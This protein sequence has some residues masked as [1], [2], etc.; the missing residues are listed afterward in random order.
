MIDDKR[1]FIFVENPKTASYSIK[2]AL[3][4]ENNIHNPLDP[5]QATINHHIPMLIK[6][7][8]PEKWE[9]YLSF[10][11]VRNTWDRAHSFFQFYRTIAHSTTYQSMSFSEWIAADCPPPKEP[12][13]C[14]PMHGDGRFDDVLDQTR[15]IEEVDEII[16]LHALSKQEQIRALQ[17]G[18]NR[19]CKLL[20]IHS[21]PIPVDGNNY[22]R[23]KQAIIWEKASIEHIH[24]K[25]RTEID[26]FN[27]QPPT[28]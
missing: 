15:Y 24:N 28:V 4:G 25:Y 3:M 13:L 9:T 22:G 5:R 16:V 23:S 17:T 18:M 27:F 6:A 14:S 12:H 20:G 10:V 19:I 2:R 21:I 1:K 7:Q 26:L 11:V 8:N